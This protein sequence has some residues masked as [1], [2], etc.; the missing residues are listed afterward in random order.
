MSTSVVA[1]GWLDALASHFELSLVD[2][3]GKSVPFE[4][5]KT[6]DDADESA[7]DKEEKA[8]TPKDPPPPVGS[9]C[10]S[11][12]IYQGEPDENGR[13]TWSAEEPDH[14]PDAAE[15]ENT[16]GHAIVIRNSK[17]EDSRKKFKMH[18]IVVQSP[19]IKKALATV[20]EGY[21]GISCDLTRLTFDAPFEPFVHRWQQLLDYM[22]QEHDDPVMGEHLRLLHSILTAELGETIKALDDYV[23]HGVVT[24]EHVWTIFVPGSVMVAPSHFGMPL[25]SEFSYGY[26]GKDTCGEYYGINS[27]CIDASGDGFG[28]SS[29]SLKMRKFA[30]VREIKSLNILP[31]AFCANEEALT[32]TLIQ[33]GKKFEQLAGFHYRTYSDSAIEVY[34]D[35]RGNEKERVVNTSGRVVVDPES[36]DTENGDFVEYLSTLSTEPGRTITTDA[37]AEDADSSDTDSDTDSY[38]RVSDG[39]ALDGE[40][41][42]KKFPE[43]TDHQRL[44]ANNLVRG[45]SLKLKKWLKF[46]VDSIEPIQWSNHAFDSLVLPTQQKEL[47]L[48]LSQ[49]QIA[50]A[51]GAFDDVI[52]GKGRG[53]ILLLTGPPGVGKTLTAESTAEQ[54]RVPLFTMGAGDLGIDSYDVEEK[55]NRILS[56]VAKWKAILLIDECDVFLEARSIHDLERNKLVSIFLRLLEYYA[57]ILFLTTNRVANMDPAFQSRIHLTI[58]YDDLTPTSRRRIWATFVDEM[59]KGRRDTSFSEKDLDALARLELNG[60]QIKNII[61]SAQLVA[62]SKQE[63]LAKK[64]VDV[65]LAIEDRKAPLMGGDATES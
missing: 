5:S 27:R 64:H 21:P 65:I 59:K 28:W 61:K 18:S 45:Y 1:P 29:Q 19:H 13:M 43:L 33:R 16:I 25:A 49:N 6:E 9:L 57:G 23:K 32:Q 62:F 34:E 4:D 22:N 24:Y 14:I 48:A 50:D 37:D 52:Q 26:Y 7:D 31:L 8:D 44:V 20:F 53:M 11:V 3:D 10:S 54:M 56:L 47:V 38:E 41:D 51:A 60:R 46:K 42:T 12:P 36:W 39:K 2:K 15:N 63:P 35:Q 17:S 40:N 55:L 58:A 30:G